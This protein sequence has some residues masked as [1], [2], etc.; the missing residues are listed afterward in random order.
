MIMVMKA[1]MINMM[2]SGN[3]NE[4]KSMTIVMI[5][6]MMMIMTMIMRMMMTLGR[7]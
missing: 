6:F 3:Y 5:M 4:K 7:Q 2:I 1:K